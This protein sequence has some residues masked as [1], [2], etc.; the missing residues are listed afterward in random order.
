MSTAPVDI[1]QIQQLAA[2]GHFRSIALWL[3]YPLVPQGIYA[4]VQPHRDPGYLQVLLEFDRPPKQDALIRLVCHRVCHLNSAIIRGLYLVGR[5][6]GTAQPLWQ[7]RVRLQQ[8][9]PSPE[10]K[11]P[12]PSHLHQVTTSRDPKDHPDEQHFPQ[13][14]APDASHTS[15]NDTKLQQ[16]IESS[17][18]VAAAAISP[19]IITTGTY[20]SDVLN[21]VPSYLIPRDSQHQDR[22]RRPNRS[23]TPSPVV[24]I[25]PADINETSRP[26]Q[27]RRIQRRRLTLIPREILEHQFK[28]V[29]AMVITGS[30]AAAFILGCVTETVMSQRG[31]MAHQKQSPTLPA[32]DQGWRPL[33]DGEAQE[34]AYRSSTRG[35][36]VPA[37]LESVAVIP[38]GSD[39]SPD[40][41]TVTLLFGGDVAVGDVP[42]QTPEAVSQVLGNLE[43][44]READVS[45]V[46]LGNTLAT[47]DT[48][49]QESY[50][51]RTRADAVNALEQGGIDIVSLSGD[52]T[53]DFGRQGLNET[54]DSLDSVGIYRVGAGR[55]SQEA[56][57]PEIL[58]VKGQRIAYLSYAPEGS[59]GAKLHKPGVNVQDL[60]GI[61]EDIAALRQAVDWIV[62]NYRW[63]GALE[64][65]PNQQQIDLSRSA[66]DAGADLVVGYHPQQLQGAELYKSRPIV[67]ALGDF[68]FQDTPLEDRDTAT[69]RVS[70]RNQQMKVEF[71][72]ISVRQARP[73]EASGENA[74]AILTEIRQASK[75]LPSPLKFPV[76]LDTPPPTEPLL[77]PDKPEPPVKTL[78]ELEPL[79]PIQDN[80]APQAPQGYDY[81]PDYPTNGEMGTDIERSDIFE[82]YDSHIPNF[83]EPI[84]E[85]L[86]Q[87]SPLLE[88]DNEIPLDNTSTENFTDQ[89]SNVSSDWDAPSGSLDPRPINHD[90]SDI[91]PL[92]TFNVQQPEVTSALDSDTESLTGGDIPVQTSPFP[93][94]PAENP[95]DSLYESD[96]DSEAADSHE[97][98]LEKQLEEET[99]SLQSIEESLDDDILMPTEQSL[100]GYDALDE[101]GEK[102]SPHKEFNP[103][104]ENLNSLNLMEEESDSDEETEESETADLA[105]EDSTDHTQSPINNTSGAISPHD[106]PLIGPLS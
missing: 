64:T 67:Y 31:K 91:N 82:S 44:F 92:E 83:Y 27:R 62:V 6:V 87:Q 19:E 52:R 26:S 89:P 58:D 106:E 78:G 61:V 14:P 77:K 102:A 32:L 73:Q 43:I 3:N 55:N 94:L 1:H 96:L 72:P 49:L 65:Q 90:N 39:T 57:R 7:Q 2:T 4:Q 45:M 46:G 41:P 24:H 38:H 95:D 12:A 33:S 75:Q 84:P 99:K 35:S 93:A 80:L 54:L 37:A 98:F 104:Q 86:T 97:D 70:L 53:M 47:A 29:R 56:R 105:V 34:I 100:P 71:L 28:Y 5:R 23:V 9:R 25:R 15:Q 16:A 51:D 101:W 74:N 85:A 63:H 59:S 69:L 20:G 10:P 17:A 8:Q 11:E 22:R 48:S 76:I 40:D 79:P 13:P 68:I 50:L 42:I 60:N 103:I 81:W 88:T 30:A 66:I 36:S 18:N 21:A